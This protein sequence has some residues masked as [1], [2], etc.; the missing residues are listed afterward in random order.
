MPVTL[1]LSYRHFYAR[2]GVMAKKL[3]TTPG[4]RI[5]KLRST[6]GRKEIL[7]YLLENYFDKFQF[8]V[9][10]GRG[11]VKNH[12]ALDEEMPVSLCGRYLED[13]SDVP[14]GTLMGGMCYVCLDT[15]EKAFKA[16]FGSR[17]IDRMFNSELDAALTR[18][19]TTIRENPDIWL[20]ALAGITI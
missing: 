6:K 3:T 11:G 5:P 17:A 9:L 10:Y 14:H 13:V 2:I 18:I 12:I 15:Y 16:W 8:Q 4:A 1:L 19:E 7:E 20:K